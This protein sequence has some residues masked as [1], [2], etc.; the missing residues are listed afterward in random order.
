M[1]SRIAGRSARIEPPLPTRQ[2]VLGLSDLPR[3]NGWT[4][5]LGVPNWSVW[6][7]ARLQSHV[8]VDWRADLHADQGRSSTAT[9]A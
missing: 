5:D 9:D 4:I 6:E 8:T 2:L 1:I 3:E 7:S